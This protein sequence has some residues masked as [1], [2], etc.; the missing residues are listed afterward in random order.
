MNC[1]Q[2]DLRVLAACGHGNTWLRF[3][4]NLLYLGHLWSMCFSIL[5]R[6]DIVA[7]RS[8]SSLKMVRHLPY[9]FA[10]AFLSPP[11]HSRSTSSV[12]TLRRLFVYSANHHGAS[13]S[14]QCRLSSA[15]LCLCYSHWHAQWILPQLHPSCKQQDNGMAGYW[16]INCF[17]SNQLCWPLPPLTFQIRSAILIHPEVPST[18]TESANLTIKPVYFLFFTTMSCT[19]SS[20]ADLFLSSQLVGDSHSPSFNQSTIQV[21]CHSTPLSS[22]HITMTCVHHCK[23]LLKDLPPEESHICSITSAPPNQTGTS[24]SWTLPCYHFFLPCVLTNCSKLTSSSATEC[25]V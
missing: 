22:I 6:C 10:Q 24:A 15:S 8:N 5:W 9:N 12:Q 2:A 13:D 4:W 23:S 1:A 11:S 17:I 25:S 14:C 21:T 19:F 20:P 3:S 16:N 7:N 18:L